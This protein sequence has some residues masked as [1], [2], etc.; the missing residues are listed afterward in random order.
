[1]LS[2]HHVHSHYGESHILQGVN[3][4]VP[5]A[6]LVVLLGR[7]GVGKTTMIHN[8]IGFHKPS[9][10]QIIFMNKNIQNLKAYQITRMGMAIVPQG[11]RVFPSLSVKENLL[12]ALSGSSMSMVKQELK[13]VFHQF[14]ALEER[15]DHKADQL[16]GGEQQILAIARALLRKPDLVLMDEP[17]EGLAPDNIKSIRL[18]I[19]ELKA[20]GS[21]ILLVDHNIKMALNFADYVYILNKG[22]IVHEGTV[23]KLQENGEL[24][25]KYLAL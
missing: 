3:L 22:K 19:A 17:F 6:S 2:I 23:S 13:K 1:M 25:K 14:P 20:A 5:R 7:N 4:Q 10:G 11:R 8:I 18:T 24:I 16:S 21:S 15:A 12:I 9:Q